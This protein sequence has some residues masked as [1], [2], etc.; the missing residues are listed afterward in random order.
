MELRLLADLSAEPY[1]FKMFENDEDAHSSIG[2]RLTGKTIR[3][4]GALGPNDPGENPE[5]RRPYKQLNFLVCY[6]GGVLKLAHKA[7]IP[8]A[9]AKQ[10]MGAFWTEFPKVKKFFTDYV[11]QSVKKRRLISPYDSRLR[12]LDGFDDHNPG[13]VSRIRNMSMN[14]PMQSGNASITKQAL[15]NIRDQIKGKDISLICTVHDS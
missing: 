9:Q 13:D 4:K 2:S 10:M 5:L 8:V 12:W 6:G 14:Y 7:K 3:K 11:E 15:C 1:W